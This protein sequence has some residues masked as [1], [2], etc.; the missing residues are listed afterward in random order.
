MGLC[1]AGTR[2]NA[3]KIADRQPEGRATGPGAHPEFAMGKGSSLWFIAL[4]LIFNGFPGHV[5]A[6]ELTITNSLT[7]S[8][9]YSD[10]IDLNPDGQKDEAF[11]TEVTP[12][13]ELRSTGARSEFAFD[14][15]PT[16]AYQTAGDD[17]G[18]Q[19]IPKVAGF[20]NLELSEELLFFEAATSVTKELLNA[21][22]ADAESNR[23]T[24][25]TIYASPYLASRFGP[26]ATSE[27]RYRFQQVFVDESGDADFS[28]DTIHTGLFTVGSEEGF[29]NLGW[30][31]LAR[32][33]HNDRSSDSNIERADVLASLEYAVSPIFSLIGGGG[34]QYFDDGE[35]ENK[36]DDPAWEAGVRLHS[37]RGEVRLTYGERDGDD[38][39]RA[40]A[41]YK[42]G[43]WTS[44]LASYSETLE[45]G[46]ER[47]LSDLSSIGEDPDTGGLIDTR[48]GLPFDP[49]T[50]TTSLSNETTWTKALRGVITHA[51]ERNTIGLR[52]SIEDQNDQTS[53]DDEKIQT[54]EV[55]WERR[56]NRRW[57]FRITG[58]YE[59]SKFDDDNTEDDEYRA[60][61]LVSYNI[62][63]NL[64]AFASYLYRTKDSDDPADEFEEN[65]FTIGLQLNF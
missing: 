52:G 61:G 43:A 8:Q 41:R 48:T 46:Q 44:L 11:V 10:N 40:E 2:W 18:F 27:L 63:Q 28:D 4:F 50:S 60:N 26:Y 29:S 7:T 58:A 3:L 59:H 64:S 53:N 38:S 14:A 13:M 19:F 17:E 62:K 20:G 54:V 31:F 32:G 55:F 21:Q 35:S 23:D 45:T 36:V 39:F 33:S 65:R 24:V 5:W 30:E 1:L 25:A 12:S 15:S 37:P 6:G 9:G 47:V 42:V 56:M 57:S 16:L 34:Y 51:R 22:A 49:N